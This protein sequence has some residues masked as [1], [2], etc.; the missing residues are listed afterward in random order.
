MFYPR[1]DDDDVFYLFLQKQQIV[2]TGWR[3]GSHHHAYGTA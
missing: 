3:V 1:A 2:A